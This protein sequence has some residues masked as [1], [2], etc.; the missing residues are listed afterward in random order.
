MKE[1]EEQFD[2]KPALNL[3]RES[4]LCSDA[5]RLFHTRGAP[6]EKLV[7]ASR[8]LSAGMIIASQHCF[9]DCNR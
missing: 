8:R 4:A 5:G 9:P 2:R 6:F 7:V 1:W 3:E